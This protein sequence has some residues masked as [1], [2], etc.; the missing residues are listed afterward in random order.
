MLNVPTSGYMQRRLTQVL[1]DCIV[2]FDGTVRSGRNI[3]QFAYGGDGAHAARAVR[4]TLTA[5]ELAA[6]RA[7]AEAGGDEA[8][9][10]SVE[11][12][13]RTGL[14]LSLPVALPW[15]ILQVIL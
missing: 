4:V 1:K 3:I 15:L 12:I 8:L 11:I 5:A 14:D 2:C 13:E 10:D 7:E 9:L 6:A